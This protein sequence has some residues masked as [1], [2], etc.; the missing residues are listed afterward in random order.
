MF[1]WI[2]CAAREWPYEY[3]DGPWRRKGRPCCGVLQTLGEVLRPLRASCRDGASPLTPGQE[4]R[5]PALWGSPLSSIRCTLLAMVGGVSARYA[6]SVSLVDV[7][8]SPQSP[9][10]ALVKD[11]RVPP[12]PATL[13]AAG[14]VRVHGSPPWEPRSLRAWGAIP[15]RAPGAGGTVGAASAPHLAAEEGPHDRISC[16]YKRIGCLG[17]IHLK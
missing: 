1:T 4:W 3:P 14:R 12:A 8:D 2:V 5:V 11:P 13:E 16:K 17:N 6:S 10:K 7:A 15:V 9:C